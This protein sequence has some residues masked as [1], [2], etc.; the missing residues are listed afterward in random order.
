MVRE[1]DDRSL[2]L[3]AEQA[4]RLGSYGLALDIWVIPGD[5]SWHTSAGYERYCGLADTL[6]QMRWEHEAIVDLLST[7]YR[8]AAEQYGG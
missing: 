4:E 3:I 5:G 6:Q 1:F 2:S 7:A 8:A